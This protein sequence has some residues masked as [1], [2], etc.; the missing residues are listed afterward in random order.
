M[1]GE[2]GDIV[3]AVG[4]LVGAHPRTTASLPWVPQR[5]L[6]EA[7]HLFIYV[8][9]SGGVSGDESSRPTWAVVVM[10]QVGDHQSLLGYVSGVVSVNPADEQFLGCDAAASGTA[11]LSAIVWALLWAVQALAEAACV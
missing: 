7:E 5:P 9:G 3:A 11:K 6:A 4:R 10:A 8:D 1:S 2:G